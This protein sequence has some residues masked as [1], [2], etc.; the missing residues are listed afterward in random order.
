M[1][2][3]AQDKYADFATRHPRI[4]SSLMNLLDIPST[5]PIDQANAVLYLASDESRYVTATTMTVDAGITQH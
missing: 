1:L 2:D 3:G 4:G 5:E